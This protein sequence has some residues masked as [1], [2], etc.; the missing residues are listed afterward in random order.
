LVVPVTV[1]ASPRSATSGVVSS[2]FASIDPESGEQ[3]RAPEVATS[4]LIDMTSTSPAI[5]RRSLASTAIHSGVFAIATSWD[6]LDAE[7]LTPGTHSNLLFFDV[8]LESCECLIDECHCGIQRIDI[9]GLYDEA[10]TLVGVELVFATPELL[11]R[12][13]DALFISG[14]SPENPNYAE[15]LAAVHA[16]LR[17]EISSWA[18]ET[19][20][21]RH[22]SIEADGELLLGDAYIGADA[23]L[24]VHGTLAAT[25][26]WEESGALSR[27]SL[28]RE[29]P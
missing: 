21:I 22:G 20:G 8:D 2:G 15:A 19:S 16:A 23:A 13:A 12:A 7:L 1:L 4:T 5:Q 24:V 25:W 18:P 27:V 29:L 10:E 9:L 11:A 6:E 26:W 14:V 28:M 17:A 3:G